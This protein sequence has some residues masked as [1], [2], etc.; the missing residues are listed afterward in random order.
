MQRRGR[1]RRNVTQCRWR[2]LLLLSG[3]LVGVRGRC[4]AGFPCVLSGNGYKTVGMVGG[5]FYCAL[6][7]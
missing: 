3:G 6:K 7:I 5:R 2:G 1:L 4:G